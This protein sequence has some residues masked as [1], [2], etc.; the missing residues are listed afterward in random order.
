M[1]TARSLGSVASNVADSGVV[2][3]DGAD[4][5]AVV[6]DA[7]DMVADST[8]G[9]G[10][11]SDTGVDACVAGS[12]IGAGAGAGASALAG[13]S[14]GFTAALVV[15]ANV[16]LFAVGDVPC[17]PNSSCRGLLWS[18]CWKSRSL[19]TICLAAVTALFSSYR[20]PSMVYCHVCSLSD[21]AR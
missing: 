10:G 2:A 17:C 9:T 7:G 16:G 20:K 8:A 4:G 12:G 13:V 19:L 3:G 5:L 21:R 1:H 15:A 14:P 11:I 18:P 6:V